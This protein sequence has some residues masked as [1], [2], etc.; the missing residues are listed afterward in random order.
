[1]LMFKC[2]SQFASNAKRLYGKKG[3]SSIFGTVFFDLYLLGFQCRQGYLQAAV[4]RGN[5]KCFMTWQTRYKRNLP[6]YIKAFNK[7]WKDRTDAENKMAHEERE[8]TQSIWQLSVLFSHLKFPMY[9]TKPA[10]FICSPW[11]C[12]NLV[13]HESTNREVET[14]EE[15]ANQC[16]RGTVLHSSKIFIN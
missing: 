4:Q 6:Q 9:W 8:Q 14:T 7:I 10:H 5:S 2:D 15:P 1:M 13:S 3:Y 11:C 16:R 12:K